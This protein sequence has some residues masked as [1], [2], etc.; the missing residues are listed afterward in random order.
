MRP[1]RTAAMP[2]QAPPRAVSYAPG[3]PSHP[4]IIRDRGP[5]DE[6]VA[7]HRR[8][9]L[10][11][12]PPGRRSATS[13]RSPPTSSRWSGGRPSPGTRPSGGASSG[14]SP[15]W[16]TSSPRGSRRTP[17]GTGCYGHVPAPSR[18][19]TAEGQSAG[20][21]HADEG[22]RR[23]LFVRPVDR[24]PQMI[25]VRRATVTRRPA[26]RPR[27]R[28]WHPAPPA[29]RRIVSAAPVS[30]REDAE[31]RPLAPA[32]PG[33]TTCFRPT[34]PGR[35]A[36]PWARRVAPGRRPVRRTR[37]PRWLSRFDGRL[38]A[39][40]VRVAA[41]PTG[42]A[43]SS[44]P[45]R[46]GGPGARDRQPAPLLCGSPDLSLGGRAVHQV[47]VGTAASRPREATSCAL[48]STSR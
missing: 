42:R 11:A 10:S 4:S 23:V 40:V 20:D 47:T 36:G 28:R 37:T 35:P 26:Q 14:G 45:C 8:R 31:V 44:R 7:R 16:W 18:G 12:W 48:P 13:G 19:R 22:P 27:L 25:H 15:S 21:R 32:A 30:R 39:G 1:S 33:R 17:G 34:V 29:R 2:S 6:S 5:S 43:A 38:C 9:R 24:L 46:T 3:R 41:P